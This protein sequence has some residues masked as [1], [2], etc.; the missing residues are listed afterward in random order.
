MC[1]DREGEELTVR[2][3]PTC[4]REGGEG[5]GAAEESRGEQLRLVGSS[6]RG[7]VEVVEVWIHGLG[8]PQV[9]PLHR[10]QNTILQE[11][12]EI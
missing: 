11:T 8:L 2:V 9:G 5:G 10:R 6:S 3:C 7:A 1:S 4:I 12:H